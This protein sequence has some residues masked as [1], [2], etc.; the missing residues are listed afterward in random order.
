MPE[1]RRL[2]SEIAATVAAVELAL[3]D[4]EGMFDQ[5]RADLCEVDAETLGDQAG[6]P[7][8]L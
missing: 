3:V 8:D 2:H 6:T 5:L 7:R 1:G 4:S